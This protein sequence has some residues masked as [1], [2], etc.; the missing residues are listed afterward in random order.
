MDGRGWKRKKVKD[1]VDKREKGGG[2]RYKR[3]GWEW[4]GNRRG[5][6][7]KR[8]RRRR[9]TKEKEGDG[10]R[11]GGAKKELHRERIQ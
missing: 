6:E 7:D 3:K 10:E 11:S 8:G 4:R 5:K 1:K 9:D 2:E